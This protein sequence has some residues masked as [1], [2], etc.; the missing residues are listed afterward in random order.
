M[1]WLLS[2]AAAAGY[3]GDAR[4]S[5]ES[6]TPPSP[7]LSAPANT[8]DLRGPSSRHSY[9]D[10]D[11]NTPRPSTAGKLTVIITLLRP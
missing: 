9:R 2:L 3:R 8:A 11:R 6:S 10:R 4:S 5:R 7:C 1:L